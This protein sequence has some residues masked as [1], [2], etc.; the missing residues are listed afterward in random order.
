MHRFYPTVSPVKSLYKEPYGNFSLLNCYIISVKMKP[1]P[2]CFKMSGNCWQ[3][4]QTAK[5]LYFSF[6]QQVDSLEDRWGGSF[7][8]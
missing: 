2:S 4:Q 7:S 1:F 5:T 8:R 6:S 3:V